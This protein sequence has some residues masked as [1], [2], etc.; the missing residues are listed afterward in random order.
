MCPACTSCTT[1]YILYIRHLLHNFHLGY[2]TSC[3]S[4]TQRNERTGTALHW[5]AKRNHSSIVSYLLLHG[6]DKYMKTNTGETASQLSSFTDIKNMLG[7]ANTETKQTELPINPSYLVNPP[8]P[9]T[10]PV[11]QQKPVTSSREN[12]PSHQEPTL[13]ATE[14][15]VIKIRVANSEERDFIEVELDKESLSF[16]RLLNVCC[17]ELGVQKGHI[18]KVRKLPNT[19]IR[20]DKDVR[21]LVDFQE[22]EIVLRNNSD[23]SRP[24]QYGISM[25]QRILY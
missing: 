11:V 16:E 22:I 14:E 1:L 21:R 20:K 5:V 2:N 4:L 10:Q 7:G 8:F 18:F 23:A 15:L 6:A 24:G 3:I 13:A 17:Q 12:L 9:Y 19:I 25:S